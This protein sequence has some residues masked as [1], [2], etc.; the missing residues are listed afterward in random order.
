[1]DIAGSRNAL[2]DKI[3]GVAIV[4][5]VLGHAIQ[6]SYEDMCHVDLFNII[7]SFHM[8]L[9]MFI[10]G[11]V[12]YKKDRIINYVWL[13]KKFINLVLPFFSWI[14]LHFMFDHDYNGGLIS[15]C[16]LALKS[17]DYGY[18]FLW[19]LFLLCTVTYVSAIIANGL[20]IKHS[21]I[22]TI[23]ILVVIYLGY[24]CLNIRYLGIP[25]LLRHAKYYFAG[26]YMRKYKDTIKRYVLLLGVVCGLTWIFTVHF[27]R[28][29]GDYPFVPDLHRF[30]AC[31][32]NEDGFIFTTLYTGSILVYNIMIAFGGIAIIFAVVSLADKWIGSTK[33]DVAFNFLG[34]HT[35]EIYILHLFFLNIMH[36]SNDLIQVMIN[37]VIALGI[38]VLIIF[39]IQN[40]RIYLLLFGKK[41]QYL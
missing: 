14:F 21:E 9:F 27:W 3:R 23:F 16:F 26:Y 12:A 11:L 40:N 41:D 28:F 39:C 31:I 15:Y 2:Y 30:L 7:Y 37:L 6:W 35:I 24:S 32:V 13:K 20:K 29:L 1:M 5:V 33:I 8:P 34:K 18:W 4:L 22:I 17:P 38:P 36:A 10:S 25:L 19:V